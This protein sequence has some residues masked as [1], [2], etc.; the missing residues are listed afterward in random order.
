KLL[1]TS[2]EPLKVSGEHPW[3]VPSLLSPDPTLLPSEEKTLPEIVAEYDAVRLFVERAAPQRPDF[4]LT[5]QNARTVAQV[6]HCLDGIPLAL[7]LAAARNKALTVEQLAPRLKDRFR[8]L[9]GD[10]RT[11]PTRQQTL[12]AMM[13]WSYDL[14][15][16]RERLLLRRL[17]VFVGGW[18]LE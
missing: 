14:L 5:P 9:T 13:D 3:R 7:E 16:E 1:A 6:C 17:S 4:A 2:R 11:V 10:N 8:L 12:R 15:T 18:T